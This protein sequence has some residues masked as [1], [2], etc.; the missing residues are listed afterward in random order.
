MSD[1]GEIESDLKRARENLDR[2]LEEMNRKAESA[3]AIL[4]E[5]P[6]RKYPMASLCGA[7]ALGLAAGGA[8]R[9]AVILGIIAIGALIGPNDSDS[10]HGSNR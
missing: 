2:T 7:M 5:Q 6:I 4:A 10:S 8:P 1:M 3:T 9:L